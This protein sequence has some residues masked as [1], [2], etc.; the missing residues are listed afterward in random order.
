[1]PSGL[2]TDLIAVKSWNSPILCAK[3]S[4]APPDQGLLSREQGRKNPHQNE[5]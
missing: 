1:M 4:Y 5:G 2:D 3:A